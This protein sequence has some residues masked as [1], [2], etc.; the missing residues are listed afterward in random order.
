MSVKVTPEPS[1]VNSF[2]GFGSEWFQ[3]HCWTCRE[4]VSH[5]SEI[6]SGKHLTPGNFD[7]CDVVKNEKEMLS[8]IDGSTGE[9]FDKDELLARCGWTESTA[10]TPTGQR[11]TMM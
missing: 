3:S 11:P 10:N 1:L 2:W 9:Y 5:G 6:F 7:F 4:N 8:Q